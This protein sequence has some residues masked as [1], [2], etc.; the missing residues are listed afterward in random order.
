V[1]E[2]KK[3]A[4]NC[5][6]WVFFQTNTAMPGKMLIFYAEII[7]NNRSDKKNGQEK[8]PARPK[9]RRCQP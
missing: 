3:F 7:G 6:Y 2:M 4:T 5:F 1:P 8:P 9:L